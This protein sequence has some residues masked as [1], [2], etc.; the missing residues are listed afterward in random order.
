MENV[1]SGLQVYSKIKNIMSLGF[2]IIL[3]VFTIFAFRY[4]DSYKY[5]KTTMSNANDQGIIKINGVPYISC[6][7]N[8]P[9]PECL[10]INIPRIYPIGIFTI[11]FFAF[12]G[13]L[14][15][16]YLIT[17]YKDYASVDGGINAATDLSRG[18]ASAFRPY[19]Y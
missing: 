3:I 8:D 17:K 2:I 9:D 6:V 19:R 18:V 4:F 10:S 5:K 13:T 16:L 1:Q 14:L 12:F 11:L 15:N 7:D